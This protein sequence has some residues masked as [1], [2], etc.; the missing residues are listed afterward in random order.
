MVLRRQV[1]KAGWWVLA[2]AVG[3]AVGGAVAVA[4]HEVVKPAG[5]NAAVGAAVGA[6][7]AASGI[8]QWLFLRRKVSRAGWWVLANLVGAAVGTA[9][10]MFLA[11]GGVVVGIKFVGDVLGFLVSLAMYGAITGGVMVWLLRQ[12]AAKEIGPRQAAE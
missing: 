12:P 5:V 3:F 10:S 7:L 2:S 8:P 4:V 11:A 1:S 6:L 9:F